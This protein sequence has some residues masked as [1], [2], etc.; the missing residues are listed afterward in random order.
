MNKYAIILAAGKGTRMKSVRADMSKVSYPI[1]G[2]PLVKYVLKA[3]KPLE[4][5]EIIT[6]VGFGGNMTKSIVENETKIVWQEVQKGTG[7]AVM[8]VAPVLEG[9]EGVTIVTCG[10]T[11]LLTSSTLK[12]L[13]DDHIKN[14]NKLTV[15]TAIVP[16]PFGY[17]RIIRKSNGNVA[18]IV[19]QK[20][21]NIEEAKITEVNTGVVV[22][23]NKL[24]FEYLKTLK[25]D[26]AQGEYY[27]Y[28]LIGK[29][30]NDGLPVGVSILDDYL[31]M[32]GINDRCQ[33]AEATKILRNRTNKALMLSGVTIEDPDS[34]YI[35]VDVKIGPDTVIKPGCYITGNTTIGKLN[36]IGPS[37]TIE[38]MEIGDEN[39][40]ISSHL[41]DSKIGNLNHVGPYARMRGHAQIGNSVKVGN[42]V[43]LKNVKLA[44]GAKSS[45]LSYLG[46]ADI[47]PDTNI[48]CGTI[49][50]NYDGV[51]K[52]HSDIGKNVFI[53][54]G[55]TIISPVTIEDDAFIAAGSTI[56]RS[57]ASGDMAIA[58]AR[59]EN[60]IGYAKVLKQKALA[61]KNK[62]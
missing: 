25:N 43:E 24:L 58:R 23:D 41:V 11:P 60:K 50:A 44:D 38:N 7:H 35:G 18:K 15:L 17:G 34:T 54:S 16:N 53:G 55:T 36:E 37:S 61:K 51:N 27:L 56:N 5:D 4:L 13:M 22:F 3:L 45:H 12:K 33:L 19:E 20:D 6:I 39:V 40:I 31:E 29:F 62:I 21:A 48:G 57:V 9:K 42:F 46:D 47:G 14:G 8:Q 52:F 2:I 26:N 10:D 59:Q 49:I 32:L 1:L 28:D 30:V